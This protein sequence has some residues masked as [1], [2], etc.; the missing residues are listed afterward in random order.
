[1]VRSLSEQLLVSGLRLGQIARPVKPVRPGEQV[2][3]IV[4]LPM[5]W[6]H[7]ENPVAG[8]ASV[9]VR[10]LRTRNPG[11]V[12]PDRSAAGL[13]SR[14]EARRGNRSRTLQCQGVRPTLVSRAGWRAS[15]RSVKKLLTMFQSRRS[16]EYRLFSRHG[17]SLDIEALPPPRFISAHRNY[18]ELP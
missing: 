2:C 18:G 17:A 6:L 11:V 1:M 7:A 12:D 3:E 8:D 13:R 10:R 16:S 15:T 14:S 9:M 4:T 5:A